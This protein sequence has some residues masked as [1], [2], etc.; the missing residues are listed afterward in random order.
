VPVREIRPQGANK[1]A[2]GDPT[3]RPR[4]PGPFD[5]PGKQM[6]RG[7]NTE[8]AAHDTDLIRVEE[9]LGLDEPQHSDH[10]KAAEN[11]TNRLWDIRLP[12]KR[13][14]DQNDTPELHQDLEKSKEGIGTA[15]IP[16]IEEGKQ[17][18]YDQPVLI[19]LSIECG[20][21]TV[22]VKPFQPDPLIAERIPGVMA[23]DIENV[24]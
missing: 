7:E 22:S 16:V 24:R 3:E 17:S 23:K 5:E 2:N 1:H 19:E 12:A 15:K 4:L 14:N 8:V 6:Q 9:I 21:Q 13:K 11:V 18:R 20:R 10:N